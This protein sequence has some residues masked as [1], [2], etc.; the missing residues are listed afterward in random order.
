[1]VVGEIL[2]GVV[3]KFTCCSV[4]VRKTS[5]VAMS[6]TGKS[7]AFNN[8]YYVCFLYVFVSDAFFDLVTIRYVGF[9]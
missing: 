6:L 7:P 3:L 5:V 4:M 8:D 9:E 1:M 2:Q